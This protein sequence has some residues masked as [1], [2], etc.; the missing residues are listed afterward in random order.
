LFAVAAT[1]ARVARLRPLSGGTMASQPTPQASVKPQ[2][3]SPQ[4]LQPS[5]DEPM[6]GEGRPGSRQGVA[7]GDISGERATI[8]ADGRP[9]CPSASAGARPSRSR[10]PI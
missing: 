1:V 9:D 10:R 8:S 4:L 6:S 3:Q 7:K 5:H 2:L